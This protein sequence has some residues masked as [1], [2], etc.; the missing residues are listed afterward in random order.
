M[1]T[2]TITSAKETQEYKNIQSVTV[3]GISGAI[4]ILSGHAEMFNLLNSGKVILEYTNKN[5]EEKEINNAQ[6]YIA[7]DKVTIIV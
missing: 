1:L 2:C 3:P 7:N 6:C 5:K 4:Q